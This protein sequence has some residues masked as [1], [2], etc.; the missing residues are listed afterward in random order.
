MAPTMDLMTM[1][2]ATALRRMF[3][4]VDRLFGNRF[5]SWPLATAR[6]GLGEFPWMPELEMK[7]KDGYLTA[8]LDLPGMKKEEVTITLAEGALTIEGERKREAESKEDDWFTTER[9]YGRFFR[10]IPLPEG[11]TYEDV[12][13]TFVNGVLEVSV[14]LPATAASI[15]PRKV[16]ISEGAEKKAVKA[17]A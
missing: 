4:D 3:G 5:W 17:A 10:S 16:P 1:E 9:T 14:H 7:E 6:T 11:V 12:K 2:P 13:A 8:R 15:A